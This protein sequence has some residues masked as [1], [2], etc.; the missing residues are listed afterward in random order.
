[1]ADAGLHISISA[2]ELFKIGGLSITNS[3]LSSLIIS[4][5]LIIFAIIVRSKLTNTSHPTG[6]QNFAEWII[7]SLY[8][9]VHSV[10]NDEK[11]TK[12]F[13]PWVAT[14]FLF[15]LLNN[16]V[17]LLPGVGTIG[18]LKEEEAQTQTQSSQVINKVKLTPSVYAL[19]ADKDI[20]QDRQP[21]TKTNSQEHESIP[22][23]KLDINEEHGKKTTIFVPLFRAGTADLNTTI[24]LAFLSV[25]LTQIFGISH[26]GMKYFKKFI[27]F[28]NP[29][30][31]FV[32]ILEA[33][34]EVAKIISFAFRLFGNIFAGEVL[35][36]VTA[37]LIPLFIPLP[38]YGLEVFVGL[39]QALV[40]VMLSLIFF[41]M[42]TQSQDMH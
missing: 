28:S 30:L 15:I 33:I 8:N 9:L 38:F 31:F 11:K 5:I 1:M 42:A 16:W 6:W 25:I 19:E 24:A 4:A 17:S 32:G 21:I 12:L 26:Q 41:N 37:F 34:S 35:L 36:M 23:E 10:T 7:E 13:F 14:F 2:E 22:D 40:F 3:I 20:N 39:I 27:N 29:I 18:L